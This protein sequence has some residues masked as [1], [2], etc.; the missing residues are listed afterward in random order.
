MALCYSQPSSPPASP[1]PSKLLYPAQAPAEWQELR[2]SH[3]APWFSGHTLSLPVTLSFRFPHR[4]NSSG[5][6]SNPQAHRPASPLETCCPPVN[7]FT[8]LPCALLTAPAL[9]AVKGRHRSLGNPAH[10][11]QDSRALLY[12]Q[13]CHTMTQDGRQRHSGTPA[14]AFSVP[15]PAEQ[16]PFSTGP[17]PCCSGNWQ[18][19]LI[20]LGEAPSLQNL[21][22][23]AFA[24]KPIHLEGLYSRF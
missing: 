5:S 7:N 17:R 14:P 20:R 10:L 16:Q 1:A 4:E 6:Q 11:F 19:C 9:L 13:Q 21:G 18:P 8:P 24:A 12:T 2:A 3:G 23:A 15:N 22:C